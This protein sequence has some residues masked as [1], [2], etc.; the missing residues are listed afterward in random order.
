M[1]IK[2]NNLDSKAEYQLIVLKKHLL[3]R[4][5]FRTLVG[6]VKAGHEEGAVKGLNKLLKR[7]QA[8]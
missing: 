8:N 7:I 5:Q 3:T 4:Q 2:V 6:Q 1:S